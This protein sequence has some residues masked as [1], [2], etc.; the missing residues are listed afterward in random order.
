MY[1]NKYKLNT[2]GYHEKEHADDDGNNM[3]RW[4][5]YVKIEP[6]AHHTSQQREINVLRP[7]FLL[8]FFYLTRPIRPPYPSDN[9]RLK[10]EVKRAETRNLFSEFNLIKA[11]YYLSL[12]RAIVLNSIYMCLSRPC[13]CR[14]YENFTNEFIRIRDELDKTAAKQHIN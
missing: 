1:V 10:I 5:P 3:R 14:M 13:A 6:E 2:S 12:N 8:L 9:S 7:Y 11:N 4:L